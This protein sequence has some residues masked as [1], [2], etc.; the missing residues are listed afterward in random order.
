MRKSTQPQDVNIPDD[1][2]LRDLKVMIKSVSDE[3]KFWTDLRCDPELPAVD[4]PFV[5]EHIKLYVLKNNSLRRQIASRPTTRVLCEKISDYIRRFRWKSGLG[6]TIICCGV[7]CGGYWIL[8]TNGGTLLI[9]TAGAVSGYL[10]TAETEPILV[11]WYENDHSRMIL[12]AA[13]IDDPRV[14]PPRH[15]PVTLPAGVS[16]YNPHEAAMLWGTATVSNPY[17]SADPNPYQS[18]DTNPYANPYPNPYSSADPNPGNGPTYIDPEQEGWNQFSQYLHNQIVEADQGDYSMLHAIC[19]AKWQNDP[20]FNISKLLDCVEQ[21]KQNILDFLNNHSQLHIVQ[22]AEIHVGPFPGDLE[23]PTRVTRHWL[24]YIAMSSE[25][26]VLVY[27]P[28][29]DGN[30]NLIKIRKMFIVGKKGQEETYILAVGRSNAIE[31]GHLPHYNWMPKMLSEDKQ[32]M[33]R[34]SHELTDNPNTC[35]IGNLNG[36]IG[37]RR[38]V[39][40]DDDVGHIKPLDG[41]EGEINHGMAPISD[42]RTDGERQIK[43][44]T[45]QIQKNG[46][47]E[48]P[49][50]TDAKGRDWKFIVLSIGVVTLSCCFG[51]TI[52]AFLC[53]FLFALNASN[54]SSAE[55]AVGDGTD[56]EPPVA[57]MV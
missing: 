17:Q 11:D 39:T 53:A 23:Y 46:H 43:D 48:R 37:A 56:L 28:V 1:L 41:Q 4:I 20:N 3:I 26:N 47:D 19:R 6:V 9:T 33:L 31:S 7:I 29:F 51:M 24:T 45:G 18:A 2:S 32:T 10:S 35:T 15:Q 49:L 16:A 8:C 25:I 34:Y 5:D 27:E 36:A 55:I 50:K 42:T 14:S 57:D 52:C 54:R 44:G 21:E 12:S 30:G 22:G 13:R 38:H 40:S